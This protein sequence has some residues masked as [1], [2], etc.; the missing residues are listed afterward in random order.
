MG[1]ITFKSN[2][3]K[4]WKKYCIPLV[5]LYKKGKLYRTKVLYQRLYMNLSTVQPCK[6]V[7]V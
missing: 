4:I 5:F 1:E 6:F 3:K 2:A 7:A